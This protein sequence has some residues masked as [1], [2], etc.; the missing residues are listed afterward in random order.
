VLLLPGEDPEEAIAELL[1]AWRTHGLGMEV[2]DEGGASH[3]SPIDHWAFQG[4]GEVLAER[5]P[6]VPHG[7]LFLPSTLT[8]ARFLRA[9][10]V[11]TFG[12]SPFAVLTPEVLQQRSYGTTNERM[13][14]PGYIE[15]VEL[16]AE[17]LE[18]LAG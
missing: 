6:K 18:R 9:A 15:G 10:G 2:F 1:P 5:H 14:L 13:S 11:P 7:P 16:Y 3:G 17:V 4:I 8:D 12:F